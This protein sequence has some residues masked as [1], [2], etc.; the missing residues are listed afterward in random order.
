MYDT[1]KALTGLETRAPFTTC[2]GRRR[3]LSVSLRN[4]GCHSVGTENGLMYQ[5]PLGG[6]SLEYGNGG[7]A[8]RTA[9]VA[10]RTGHSMLLTLYGQTLK[11][12]CQF[13]IAWFALDL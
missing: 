8:Y 4:M 13:H 3:E 1:V 5:R 10:D 6:Q 2:V 7:Q 11:H 9:C 12:D